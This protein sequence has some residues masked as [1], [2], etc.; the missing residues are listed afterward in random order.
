MNELLSGFKTG[1]ASFLRLAGLGLGAACGAP[2]L[3]RAAGG[4]PPR[5]YNTPADAL[6]ALKAGDARFTAG[7][8]KNCTGQT[9]RMHILAEGQNPFAIVLGCADS[10]VPVEQAFDQTPGSIFTVR[11]AG[12][13]VNNDGLGSIE[14]AVAALKAIV[15]V[16]LGHTEC[17][18]MKA[19]MAFVKDGTTQP[20]HIQDFVAAVAPAAKATQG[21]AG[22]WLAN[23]TAENVRMNMAA[24][25][26]RSSI[27]ADAK[28]SGGIQIIGGVYDIKNARVNYLS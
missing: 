11:V 6:A 12:N 2:L 19:A 3:A 17:G 1:R 16:V 24:L 7:D 5:A 13:F 10:R 4:G 9:E 15:I 8:P 22:D 28:N 14:Y 26:K 18:A 25:T 21:M 20:G 23:A 27:V